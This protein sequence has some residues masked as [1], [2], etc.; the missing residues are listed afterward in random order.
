MK[1]FDLKQ[2]MKDAW[3]TYKYVARKKGKTFG[4]VLK[5]T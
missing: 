5:S 2:I 1:R 4:E 3:R